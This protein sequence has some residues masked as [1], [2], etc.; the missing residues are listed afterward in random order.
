MCGLEGVS[1]GACWPL[2]VRS[3]QGQ[4]AGRLMA[5][6]GGAGDKGDCPRGSLARARLLPLGLLFCSQLGQPHLQQ[7]AHDPHP[8][9]WD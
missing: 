2:P 1:P 6:G 9:L 3:H 7:L 8:G 5:W 4:K